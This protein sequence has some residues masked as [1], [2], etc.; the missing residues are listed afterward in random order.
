MSA[1][2]YQ[3]PRAFLTS[4]KYMFSILPDR[5]QT[6]EQQL[7]SVMRFALYFTIV[8]LII[9]K[10]VRVLYFLAFVAA[11]IYVIYTQNELEVKSKKELF[12]GLNITED[13]KKRPC[14]KP[15][16]DNPFMNVTFADYTDFPN[17]PKACN[18]EDSSEEV[19]ANF[20]IGLHRQEDD[21]YAKTA[22]DRQYMTNPI[23]TIPNNQTGFA[24]WLY[25]VGPTCKEK[26]MSCSPR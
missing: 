14:V 17:R 9:Q 23:T 11:I 25:K 12:N 22:S 15:S 2:W 19:A 7:N 1:I 13:F 18:I 20:E 24:E 3:D 5:G 4:E 21:A 26:G 8:M 10:D 16:K 6:L